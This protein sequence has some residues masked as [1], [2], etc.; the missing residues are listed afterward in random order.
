MLCVYVGPVLTI[1]IRNI[2]DIA[3]KIPRFLV[4]LWFSIRICKYRLIFNTLL[5]NELVDFITF[6]TGLQLELEVQFQYSWVSVSAPAA[7]STVGLRC[8][9]RLPCIYNTILAVWL[10]MNNRSLLQVVNNHVDHLL[11]LILDFTLYRL[12][13]KFLDI[14]ASAQRICNLIYN[15]L[16]VYYDIQQSPKC[17]YFKQDW[18]TPYCYASVGTFMTPRVDWKKSSLAAERMG[19]F[20]KLQGRI[21]NNIYSATWYE[22][23][24][25]RILP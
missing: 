24:L 10:L 19:F 18:Y 7:E 6:V 3:A 16:I 14:F 23:L 17:L 22:Q 12:G 5:F 1:F 2:G 11:S 25:D 4:Q 21:L 13:Q 9:Q 8:H 20:I 15:S